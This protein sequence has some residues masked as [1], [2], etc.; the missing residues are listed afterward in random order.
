MFFFF[1]QKHPQDGID[2]PFDIFA[3]YYFSHILKYS[4]RWLSEM[5]EFHTEL[6]IKYV[7]EVKGISILLEKT[8]LADDAI[9]FVV[10]FQIFFHL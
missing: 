4:L 3:F 5:F 1:F 8:R 6:H 9:Y 2:S 10:Q 7:N